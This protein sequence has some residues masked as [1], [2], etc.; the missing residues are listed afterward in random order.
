MLLLA[1]LVAPHLSD[2]S[3]TPRGGATH[4]RT[5]PGKQLT[6]QAQD[7]Y[8]HGKLVEKGEREEKGGQEE[9]K[10]EED[11]RTLEGKTVIPM[12]LLELSRI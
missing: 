12:H 8:T 4:T 7:M 2:A 5:P 10:E 6:T 9:E 11:I 3:A 1:R